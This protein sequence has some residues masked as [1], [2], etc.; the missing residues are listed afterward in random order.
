MR[1][2][3]GLLLSTPSDRNRGWTS[4]RIPLLTA[5]TAVLTASAGAVQTLPPSSQRSDQAPIH[6]ARHHHVKGAMGQAATPEA[7][8]PAPAPAPE[9]PHWPA[10]D[11]P[12]K[13]D[14]KW[15][16]RGLQ[17]DAANSSL[18]QILDEVSTATGTKVEGMGSDERV[19]GEYGPGDARDVLSQLLVGSGYNV[20]MIG[21]QGRGTPREIVLSA[22]HS[23]G[24]QNQP[25]V[26]PQNSD[27]QDEETPEVPDAEEQGPPPQQLMRPPIMQQG[28]PGAPGTPRTPQQLLQELQQRQQQMQNDQ[29]QQ[30]QQQPQQPPQ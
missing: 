29:M 10:N 24:N 14:I 19:F 16:S 22:R 15:D 21:D 27:V 2:F 9:P 13:P 17:I 23:A 18:H 20:L 8:A 5:M 28:P 7:V 4:R 12:G 3:N 30:Q 25:G 1:I 26:N 6:K 11:A